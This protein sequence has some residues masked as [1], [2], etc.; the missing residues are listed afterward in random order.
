MI[1]EMEQDNNN[2]KIE[3]KNILV[4]L[5]KINIMEGVS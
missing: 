2:L 1:S 5:L 3:Q 4:L